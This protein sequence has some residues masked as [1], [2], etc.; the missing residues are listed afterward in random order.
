M[1]QNIA[2]ALESAGLGLP[3]RVDLSRHILGFERQ[4][5]DV[6]L[7]FICSPISKIY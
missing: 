2:P 6:V 3:A 7:S 5:D 1:T 4:T